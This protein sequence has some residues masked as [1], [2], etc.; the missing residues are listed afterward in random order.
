MPT[1]SEYQNIPALCE[2]RRMNSVPLEW[3]LCFWRLWDFGTVTL[4]MS[5]RGLNIGRLDSS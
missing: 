4:E 1:D 5:R 3:T 2:G